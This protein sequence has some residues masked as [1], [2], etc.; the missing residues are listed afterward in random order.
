MPKSR[1]I[2]NFVKVSYESSSHGASFPNLTSPRHPQEEVL[3]S[4]RG[5]KEKWSDMPADYFETQWK[6]LFEAYAIISKASS[7]TNQKLKES[8]KL[9]K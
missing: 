4:H 8:I 3:S 7:S 1:R 9:G 2:K 5:A 6:D